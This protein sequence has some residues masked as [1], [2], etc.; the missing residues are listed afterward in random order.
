MSGRFPK[1]SAREFIR[2]LKS[3]QANANYS[4]IENPIIFESI[5]NIGERPYGRYGIRKKRTHVKIIAKE[6]EIK[7]KEEKTRPNV[8]ELKKK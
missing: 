8:A 5:A 3:L 2:L 4:G 7:K 6:R 1:K